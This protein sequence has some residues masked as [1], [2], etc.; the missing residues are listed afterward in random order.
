M[1]KLV[2]VGSWSG[3]DEPPVEV[4][5]IRRDGTMGPNDRSE[6]LQ[7]RGGS[8]VFLRDLEK[9]ALHPDEIPIHVIGLGAHEGYGPNRNGDTFTEEECRQHHHRFVKDAMYYRN[10]KNTD[11][12]KSYGSIKLSAYNEPMRRVELLLFGNEKQSAADRNGNLVMP[13]SSVARLNAG[14][15]LGW[16]MACKV[17]HDVCLYAG[18]LVETRKGLRPIEEIQ[19]GEEVKTHRGRW[20][21]VNKTFRRA[22]AGTTVAIKAEGLATSLRMT[23]NHPVSVVRR[24][25][26][27]DCGTTYRVKS[28]EQRKA[29]HKLDGD[30]CVRCKRKPVLKTEWSDAEDVRVGD[31]L[32]YP[33]KTPGQVQIG[34]DRAYMLGLYAGDGCPVRRRRGR[35]RQG[36]HYVTGAAWSLSEEPE[37]LAHIH[38]RAAILGETKIYPAGSGRKAVQLI[39]RN[40]EF[41]QQAIEYVGTGSATKEVKPEAFEWREADRL[42]FLAGCVDSDGSADADRQTFR[43]CVTGEKLAYTVQRLFWGLGIFASCC[44]TRA[45]G[46]WARSAYVYQLHIPIRA[47]RLLRDSGCWRARVAGEGTGREHGF[48]VDGQML[49]RV[50]EIHA[51]HDETDVFNLSV[52][53]DETYVSHVSVHNCSN[54]GNKAAHRGEYCTEETCVDPQSGRKMPG[55]RFGLTKLG[56]DG[57]QQFVYNPNSHWFDMSEVGREA[58]RIAK[59]GLA[60]YVKRA[61]DVGQVTGGAELAELAGLVSVAPGMLDLTLAHRQLGLLNKLAELEQGFDSR[62]ELER[63]AAIMGRA[64]DPESR[65]PGRFL[66]CTKAAA[67]QQIILS[68]AYFFLAAHPGIDFAKAAAAAAGS[69]ECL[70]NCF[71]LLLRDPELMLALQSNQWAAAEK[72]ADL[73]MQRWVYRNRARCSLGTN[74]AV[75]RIHGVL[76]NREKSAQAENLLG[77]K[78]P[79]TKAA[80]CGVDFVRLA[81]QHALYQLGTLSAIPDAEQDTQLLLR[82]IAGNRV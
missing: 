21:R 49:I 19:V 3:I 39:S 11:P 46:K 44:R 31:Y 35:K 77:A 5:R 61:H 42:A 1:I 59:G 38:R 62:S 40:R 55:C 17:A 69:H 34:E 18:S 13:P 12:K 50:Q 72:K 8:H 25:S 4:M 70:S 26:V 65:P 28:G 29:R 27:R 7:K 15:L 66:D 36:D 79:L 43:F 57:F 52:E 74:W 54:C 20:R 75:S 82:V 33:V 48:V 53:E 30:T 81:R 2:G 45:T 9:L 76:A 22:F 63:R 56:E 37:S 80:A 6:F 23:H 67:D 41:V 78:P 32:V 16:S 68:P 10:H 51:G 47:A 71:S 64:Q 60:D 24:E 58:D 14:E 73:D